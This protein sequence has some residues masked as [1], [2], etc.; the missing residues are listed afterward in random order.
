MADNKE[1]KT[2]K[3][4]QTSNAMLE[5]R[6]KLLSEIEKAQKRISQIE[7][8]ITDPKAN[9]SVAARNKLLKEREEL[10]EKITENEKDSEEILKRTTKTEKSRVDKLEERLEIE[11]KLSKN[12]TQQNKTLVL[13]EK[14]QGRMKESSKEYAKTNDISAQILSNN[15]YTISESIKLSK[16]QNG[17]SGDFLNTL[18]QSE[19]VSVNL[20]D[21]QS[22]ITQSIEDAAIGQYKE[23]DF[24]KVLEA[25]DSRR[26]D[27]ASQ[28]K[29]LLDGTA[30]MSEKEIEL[31]EATLVADES[32]LANL[33]DQ[34]EAMK[35]ASK[36]AEK[37]LGVFNKLLEGDFGGALR[38]Q[39]SMDKIQSDIKEKLGGSL[40]NVIKQVKEGNIAG[41]FSA[42]GEGLKSMIGMAPK[43]L[44]AM[45]VGALLMAFNFIIGSIGKLDEEI[46]NLG[47]EF[48]IS[49]KEAI[50]LHH[51]ATD[52]AGEIKLAGINSAQVAKG[53]KMTSE[54][55]G[56]IDI[57]ARLASGNE[58]AKQLVKDVTV[59]SEKFGLSAD[60]IKNVQD[61]ATMSGKS[62]GQLTAEATTLNKGLMTSKESMKMLASIPK[63]VA[64]AFKGGTQELIKAAAKAKL[65]GME[66]G[67]VQEIGMGMLNIEDSLEKEMEARVL[68]GKDLNLDAAR[69]AALNGDIVGLQNEL[70]K[71]AGSLKDFQKMGPIQQKAMADA[72]GMSVDEMTQ[73][74]TNAEKL[75]D[76]GIDQAKLTEL[77]GMNAEQL[78]KELA[79]GGNK[80]YQDYVRNLA[81]EKES[82]EVKARMADAMTKLQEKLSKMLT[83][84]IE[85][86]DRFLDVLDSVGGLD[87]ILKIV[88]GTIALIAT[89]WVGAKLVKGF[90]MVSSSI[91][92][93]KDGISGFFSMIKGPG[94]KAMSTLSDGASAVTDKVSGAADKLKENTG[95]MKAPKGGGRQA[96]GFLKGLV[97]AI[98][99]IS[100]ADIIKVAAAIVI[101][102]AAIGIAAIAFKLFGD[103]DWN[104]VAK[105][106]VTLA[107]MV[108]AVMLLGNASAQMILGA[109]AVVVLGAALIV[110]AKAMQEFSNGVSW[111][112]VLMGITTLG[113]LTLAVLALGALMMS[114][115][116]AVAIMA[117]AAALLILSAAL[118]VM[119]V[120]MQ[121]FA[122]A[123]V[124]LIPF[125]ESITSIDVGKIAAVAGT[126]VLLGGSFAMIGLM[127]PFIILGSI[128]LMAMSVSL[129]ILAKVGPTASESLTGVVKQIETI[130]QIDAGKILAAAGSLVVLGAALLGFQAMMAAG[131]VAS[132]VGG[133]LGGLLGGESPLETISK[134]SEKIDAKKLDASAK[135]IRD[136]ADAFKYFVEQTGKLKEFDT[137]K[138]DDIINKMEEVQKAQQGNSLAG[139]VTGVANRIS[140]FVGGIFGS[141]EKQSTQT[142]A[143][144][145]SGVSL[146]VAGGGTIGTGAGGAEGGSG[147]EKKL[148]VLISV[149]TK[150]VSQPT[151]IKIG[152]KTVEEIQ[153]NIDFKKA[154]DVKVGN[155]YGRG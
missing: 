99:K 124:I 140:S 88:A 102:S 21:I 153:S 79:K 155:T 50:D 71:Q 141:S 76:T 18:Q 66:L 110:A 101:L 55:M 74:L 25:I 59:L 122:K 85:M 7:D 37:T 1:K 9:L 36:Q 103:V 98:K 135:A 16:S 64:V 132:G 154:Y 46:S 104:S 24:S 38:Q 43:L 87:L 11:E 40:V 30:T 15:A 134:I 68:T 4:D 23:Q 60:E 119:G 52:I 80:A 108:G 111:D 121:Q 152:E 139:A 84:L 146:G 75:K 113:A 58:K 90:Q 149:L 19:D 91:G 97:D 48:G 131:A 100:Y 143:P 105:G 13:V 136:L 96:G 73:M 114:G 3:T 120:A 151:I 78:N 28:R 33:I 72:M 22:D 77:Q 61:L 109:A 56:G 41:A 116:G 70:L 34:N 123:A 51:T 137:A 95:K 2:L 81:K 82:E 106:L 89:V 27:L 150:A 14:A 148:D 53:M 63:G 29:G 5:E 45:G 117:G 32:H 49:K 125:L 112:G 83:P 67:K 147:V 142:V 127:V 144:A 138:L 10:Y 57:G 115:V 17:L 145:T 118:L 44:A 133:L 128:A 94:S 35:I 31:A 62:M 126:L 47:K 129:G 39:F 107:V 130:S 6:L 12:Y 26:A 69:Y 65:L 86:A 92:A 93:M 42:A 20:R 8:A 54:I